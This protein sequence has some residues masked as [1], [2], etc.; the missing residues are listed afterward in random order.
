MSRV[1]KSA[2]VPY[3]AA[4]MAAL[5]D[6]VERYPDFLPW[7]SGAT[8]LRSG[9]ATMIAT[10]HIDYRGIKQSFT[11]ENARDGNAEIRMRLPEGGL[12][13]MG[14]FSKLD[15]LWRFQAL[16]VSA[17]KV[18]LM[19]DYGFANTLLEKAVGPVFGVIANTMIERFIARAES[20]FGQRV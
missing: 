17:C 2:L 16:S 1:E 11:T 7:C 20:Q 10:I 18:T 5:V 19:L 12:R 4:E 6:D 9:A 14:P 15:G 8:A 3:S 13:S